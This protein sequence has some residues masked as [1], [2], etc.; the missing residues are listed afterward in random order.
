MG[1]PEALLL[2]G[3]RETTISGQRWPRS[4]FQARGLFGA[5]DG[6]ASRAQKETVARGGLKSI[7]WKSHIS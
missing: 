7:E 4:R 1:I 5:K 2:C 6:G 3:R